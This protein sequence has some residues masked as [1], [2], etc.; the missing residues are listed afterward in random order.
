MN[1][2]PSKLKTEYIDRHSKGQFYTDEKLMPIIFD[3]FDIDTREA[4]ILE[5]SCGCGNFIDAIIDNNPNANI[6]GVDIDKK[7]FTGLKRKYNRPNIRLHNCDFLKFVPNKQYDLV[8]GN[9][10]FNLPACAPYCNTTDA[11]VL[12]SLDLLKDNGKLIMVLPSTFLRNKQYQEA[13]DI[14]INNYKIIGIIDSNGFD[15]LGADVETLVICIQKCKVKKQKYFFFSQGFSSIINL[16]KN[17]CSTIQIHDN[18]FSDFIS[19]KIG[20]RKVIDLFDVYR[21][22]SSKKTSLKGRDID[23]YGNFLKPICNSKKPKIVVQNIAYRL[24]ANISFDDVDSI[25]DTVTIFD[26]K[27]EMTL[28]ELLMICNYLN[29]SIANYLLHSKFLNFCMLTIHIDKYYVDYLPIPDTGVQ[30]DCFVALDKHA[31]TVSFANERNEAFY[32]LY[33]LNKNEIDEIEFKWI[34]PRFKIKEGA[35]YE[36]SRTY[37]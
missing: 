30:T 18:K 14:I 20:N 33:S 21:G 7:V 12:K 31:R 8:I 36:I 17:S 6:D 24:V 22:R 9:P 26:P 1:R 16:K 32:S 28:D 15:F 2:N 23:F 11:F 27:K 35:S 37:C 5:P 19:E 13:R 34:L 10:P 25:S 29:S 3:V 4:D